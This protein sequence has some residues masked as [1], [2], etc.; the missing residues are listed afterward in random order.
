MKLIQKEYDYA[1]IMETR[2]ENS[3]NSQLLFITE[4]SS[5]KNVKSTLKAPLE[6]S[7]IFKAKRPLNADL[8][9]LTPQL[10][11]EKIKEQQS[12]TPLIRLYR[13]HSVVDKGLQNVYSFDHKQQQLLSPESNLQSKFQ[14]F[15]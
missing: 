10:Q 7:H 6:S 15:Q 1:T 12:P 11:L 8:N 3:K 9:A 14:M 4:D 2:R 5:S 13:A